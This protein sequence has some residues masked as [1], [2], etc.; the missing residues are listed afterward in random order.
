MLSVYWHTLIYSYQFWWSTVNGSNHIILNLLACIM[1]DM[2]IAVILSYI[3]TYSQN[4]FFSVGHGFATGSFIQSLYWEIVLMRI[5]RVMPLIFWAGARCDNFNC[6]ICRVL[7][8]ASV[9]KLS[10]HEHCLIHNSF[11]QECISLLIAKCCTVILSGST[12]WIWWR[13]WAGKLPSDHDNWL[14]KIVASLLKFIFWFESCSHFLF[15][16]DATSCNNL[17]CC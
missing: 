16:T 15:L 1:Y 2:I 13:T 6:V 10:F 17:C 8:M 3:F 5:W 11:Y 4:C 12:W 14:I 9:C 7:I